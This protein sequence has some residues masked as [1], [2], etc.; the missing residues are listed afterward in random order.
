M[1]RRGWPPS[2]MGR[3][4]VVARPVSC[5]IWRRSSAKT[6]CPA[7][8]GSVTRAGPPTARPPPPTP[9]LHVV[10]RVAVVHNGI[11]EN[12]APLKAELIAEGRTFESQTDTEVVAH[13]IDREL[14]KG[15]E[16]L[17]AFK[18]ML[19]QI[20]GAYALAVMIAGEKPV[21]LGARF[22]PPPGGP[23]TARGRCTSGSDA[24]AVGPFH[25]QDLL[26]GRGRLRRHRPSACANLQ[27]L[28]RVRKTTGASGPRL[29]RHGGEG[30][31]IATSC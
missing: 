11:I 23:V 18:A 16:P 29:R 10:G 1:I 25:Q 26:P 31:T 8:S 14:S 7:R 28:G 27:R 24:I 17:A 21:I 2:S 22:G 9:I 3:S 19:D 5:S 30:G 20:E 12:F 6:P 13:L 4:S 15:L